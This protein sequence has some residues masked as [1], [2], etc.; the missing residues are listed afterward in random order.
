MQ[1][2]FSESTED[3]AP[4]VGSSDPC[5]ERTPLRPDFE[6]VTELGHE[7]RAEYCASVFKVGGYYSVPDLHAD[8]P[9]DAPAGLMPLDHFFQ[10]LGFQSKSSKLVKVVGETYGIKPAYC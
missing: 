6:G 9:G 8:L 7:L 1:V 5:P 2:I 4:D 3:G 10:V